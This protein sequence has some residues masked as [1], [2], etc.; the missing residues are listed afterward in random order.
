MSLRLG[1]TFLFSVY[2]LS[3][4]PL[5]AIESS[6][7]YLELGQ[8]Y[9]VTS[10][11]FTGQVV[12][13]T[14]LTLTT[15]TYI[16]LESDGRFFPYQ[17]NGLAT[18]EIRVNGQGVSNASILDFRVAT[19]VQHSFN[20]VGAVFLFPGTH[21][22]Q[23]VAYNHPS[24]GGGQF[25][26]GSSSNLSVVVGPATYVTALGMGA[27]SG[28]INVNTAGFQPG[29]P[30]N[31]VSVLSGTHFVPVAPLVLLSSG[32]GYVPGTGYGDA[33]L[34]TFRNGICPS[35]AEHLWTVQD[36]APSGE[37]HAPMYGQALYNVTG[38]VNIGVAATELPF[39]AV[40]DPVQ[41]YVGSTTALIA[42]AGN[43]PISGGAA[44]LPQD[45]CSPN[46]YIFAGNGSQTFWNESFTVQSGQNGNVMFLLKT[47]VLDCHDF[48]GPGTILLQLELDGQPVGSVSVQ[49]YTFNNTC[50]QRTLSASYLA[51]GLSPGTH[52]IRGRITVSGLPNLAAS[53]DLGLVYFGN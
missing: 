52:T 37:L 21:T 26:I 7:R 29:G 4:S 47:R 23:L 1:W 45:N 24:V 17:Q 6:S 51:L 49:Q 44:E 28:L 3:T 10:N 12:L 20:C 9:L 11:S 41:Y 46:S 16:F 14:T 40:E 31:Y 30:L 53:G 38:Q 48:E 15:G 36:L 8:D 35:N 13:Q 19:P 50:H 43:I 18:V 22:F 2:L 5:L 42:L 32:R 25:M 34:G 33:M 39:G 27:D